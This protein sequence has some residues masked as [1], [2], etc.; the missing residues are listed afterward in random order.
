MQIKIIAVWLWH[1]TRFLEDRIRR[2]NICHILLCFLFRFFCKT[3][4][5]FIIIAFFYAIHSYDINISRKYGSRTSREQTKACTRVSVT[6]VSTCQN[7]RE[8]KAFIAFYA[9]PWATAWSRRTHKLAHPS[10]RFLRNIVSLSPAT[11]RRQGGNNVVRL[12]LPRTVAPLLHGSLCLLSVT[13][14]LWLNGT[15]SGKT[16]QISK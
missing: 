8:N 12:F 5:T 3:I 9:S 15:F 14:V 13:Y 6:A 10:C 11:K 7:C 2:Q 4:D 1:I 16:V